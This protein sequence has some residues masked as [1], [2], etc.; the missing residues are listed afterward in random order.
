MGWCSSESDFTSQ[1]KTA[2]TKTITSE[3]ASVSA[4]DDTDKSLPENCSGSHLDIQLAE[5]SI[6]ASGVNNLNFKLT[7]T[8]CSGEPIS[9]NNSIIYFDI[10]LEFTESDL[11]APVPIKINHTETQ[12]VLFSNQLA[13]IQGSDLF[14]KV[15]PNYF[16]NSS[17]PLNLG[18]E[19]NE[20]ILNIPLSSFGSISSTLND[21]P[22]FVSVF[23]KVGESKAFEKILNFSY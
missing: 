1:N 12:K 21:D 7:H 6:S 19:T 3:D 4:S 20:I 2:E 13:S 22:N 9:F 10:N 14:G 15:G 18:F 23:L 16:H 5:Q 8:T 11:F 17:E